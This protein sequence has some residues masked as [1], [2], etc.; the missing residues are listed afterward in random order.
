MTSDHSTASFYADLTPFSEFEQAADAQSYTVAPDDWYVVIADIKGSTKAIIEGRYK[1][2]NMVGAACINAVLNVSTKGE[3]PYVFGG[4]GATMLVPEHSLDACKQALLRLRTLAETRFDL[5]LRVGI[6]PVAQLNASSGHKVMVG[7]YQISPGNMLATFS[8]GGV[9]LAERWIKSDPA[10]LVQSSGDEAP[11][12]LSGLSCR[13]E[14]LNASSG[15]M[16][17]VL[18]QATSND[19]T[20]RA[21]TYRQGIKAIEQIAN[22]APN[23]GKP[24]NAGNM[25]FRWPPRGLRAEI[26]ATVGNR[27]RALWTLRVYANSLLQWMLD[28]F[29]LSAG[30]YRGKQY[31]VELR[32]NTDYQRFDDTLRMLLDCTVQQAN[33]IE[34]ML[35]GAVQRGELV[36]GTHRARSALM[37]CLV[38][39]L[40]QSQHIHFVD[41]SDGGF[42][43]AAKQMKA[44]LAAN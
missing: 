16:L 34:E 42:T 7:K 14:P 33:A 11:P 13:W 15:V 29:D 3:I 31:R 5:S 37:T 35:H 4:D 28:T 1:Q 36:F 27:N 43:S 23:A 26:D 22:D 21:A 44:L 10:Y 17:S 25:K 8:G 19:A 18:V 6:V 2:V 20:R 24:I 39:D 38:F 40:E 32:D 9:E 41:G 12:D 30:G